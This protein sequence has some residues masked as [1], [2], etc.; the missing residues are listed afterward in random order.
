MRLAASGVVMTAT[1]TTRWTRLVRR[2]GIDG[3]PL[4]RRSDMIA[5]WLLPSAIMIFFALCPAIY[6]LTGMRVRADNAAARRAEVTWHQVKGVLLQS[7]AG[8]QQPASA[9]STWTVLEPVAWVLNGKHQVS[10]VPVASDT[11]AGSHVPVLLN[12]AGTPE[13]PPLTAAQVADRVFAD[14]LVAV[15]AL[16]VLLAGLAWAIRR[17]LDR[18]RLAGWETEWLAVGPRWSR[19]QG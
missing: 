1:P 7:A 9:A 17:V 6:V 11:P 4:R 8:P 10:N 19:Q 3:N 16:A 15:A 18:R 14:T 5:A 13:M 2:L 12:Q